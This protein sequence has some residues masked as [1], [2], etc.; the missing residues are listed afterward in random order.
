MKARVK[1]YSEE[2]VKEYMDET[3]YF[4]VYRYAHNVRERMFVTENKEQARQFCEDNNWEWRDENDFVW[5]LDYT[6]V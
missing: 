3:K 5:E 4:A 1:M 2:M 6:E